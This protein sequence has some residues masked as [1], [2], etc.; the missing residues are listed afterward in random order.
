MSKRWSIRK[1]ILSAV[2]VVVCILNST[3]SAAQ[4][5]QQE[6]EQKNTGFIYF[7]IIFSTPETGFAAGSAVGYYYRNPDSDP[8]SRPSTITP[9]FIYTQKKQ[10]ITSLNLDL[11][12]KDELY[13]LFVNVNYLK[14]PDKFFG[15][16]NDL[17][18]SNEESFT[19]RKSLVFI[20][21]QRRFSP[22]LNLGLQY[23]F[24]H[25]NVIEVEDFGLLSSGSIPGS[26][27]GTVSGAGIIINR[28]TRDNIF[29]PTSG[30]WN[31]TSARFYG[32]GL[33]SDFSYSQYSIDNRQYYQIRSDHIVASQVYV[34]IM[35][36]TPP[37]ELM[38]RL[39]GANMMR[40]YY[41]GR[42]S[43]KCMIAVQSEYRM[44]LWRRLGLVGFVGFGD[45]SDKI[46]N[47]RL[48]EFKTAYG[49]G[50]RFLF[51]PEEKINLRLD[52]ASGKGASGM[53]IS[54]QEAF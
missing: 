1:T 15:I 43:D 17:P 12:L 21:F 18:E 45:V 40:G 13:R 54:I 16:G 28:D 7:P 34:N 25:S 24:G 49:F 47:F 36:G 22:G 31:Q 51:S 19:S 48:N 4:E 44:H 32:S 14:F 39:G 53:Y 41:Q 11:Y 9:M 46:S 50:L 2:L 8:D 5:V 42:Y 37:F 30:S 3:P 33:G 35:T 52:F 27:G 38:S 20:D 29:Y 10:I 26:T 6:T 23:E